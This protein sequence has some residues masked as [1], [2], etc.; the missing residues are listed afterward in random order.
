VFEEV[1]GGLALDGKAE[2]NV[3]F[4]KLNKRFCYNFVVLNKASVEVIKAKERLY[5]FNNC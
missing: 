3:I 1:E 4:Y 5:A 2:R